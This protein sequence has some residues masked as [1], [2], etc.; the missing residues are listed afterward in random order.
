MERLTS[1]AM[2]TR[3]GSGSGSG[4]M[5][6]VMPW[7]RRTRSEIRSR[8]GRRRS[9]PRRRRRRRRTVVRRCG[10]Y[11][12]AR[13]GVHH[14][15]GFIVVHHGRTSPQNVQGAAH[16]IDDVRCQSNS[17]VA[18]MVMAVSGKDGS[19]DDDEGGT[20]GGLQNRVLHF[21][22][23]VLWFMVLRFFSL[24]WRF[25]TIKRFDFRIIVI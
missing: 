15:A 3:S 7:R 22:S 13:R 4:T 10:V 12:R 25:L 1:A 24:P 23:P 11:R 8:R 19:S 14:T 9:E 6:A 17:T 16:K 2:G 18:V 5:S 20:N 21:S